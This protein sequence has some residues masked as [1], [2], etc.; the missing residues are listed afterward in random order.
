M[1]NSPIGPAPITAT[2]SPGLIC[3]R[4]SEWIAIASGSASAAW[5]YDMPPGIGLKFAIGKFTSSRKNPGWFGVLRK[6]IFAHTL[7]R[8]LRQNS[9]W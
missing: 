1:V 8:P 5:P 7:W 2:D 9:Q 6:R 4:R 3:A